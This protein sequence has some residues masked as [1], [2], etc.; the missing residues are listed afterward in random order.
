V[1]TLGPGVCVVVLLT[2]VPNV[3]E[4]SAAA[5]DGITLAT[6]QVIQ[7][8]VEAV[9]KHVPGTPDES[10]AAVSGLTYRNRVDMNA[11]MDLFL[12][13]LAGYK[14]NT[15]FNHS[16]DQ[17]ADIA[18]GAGMPDAEEFLKRA[19]VLHTDAA[20][21][22]D[23]FPQP[24]DTT[25]PPSRP[26]EAHATRRGSSL[27]RTPEPS[28]APLLT[29]A[30]F[31]RQKDGD[32]LGTTDANW[33]WPFARSLLA[34]LTRIQRGPDDQSLNAHDPFVGEWY[35]AVASFLFAQRLYGEA[36]DHFSHAAQ[37]LA[38]D[39]RLLFDR[40]CYAEILGLP[41]H[42]LFVSDSVAGAMRP[43]VPP[44][45]ETNGE[46]ERLFRRALEVD[47][48]FVE[49][50]VHLARLL[51][52]R[53]AD[54][55]A[56]SQLNTAADSNPQGVVGFYAHLFDARVSQRRGALDDA[57]AQ[58]REALA[59]YPHAQSALLGLSQVGLAGGDAQ[60]ALK[61]LERLGPESLK[62]DADPWWDYAL[63]SGRDVNELMQHVW[64]M[65]R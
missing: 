5:A 43:N 54:A 30:T 10:I 58:Y 57:A 13:A 49:A 1:R 62:G 15:N 56:A 36:T 24:V 61:A 63:A 41:V 31:V 65:G 32:V 18:H 64:T 40:G 19:T 22:V 4:R 26:S 39:P 46:A 14:Y 37:V 6:V 59:L 48:S 35:H 44:L 25:V 20:I 29:I 11:G 7:A 52:I 16:A 42:Q 33:N 17:V 45:A 21:F 23:K 3:D 60:A 9:H 8:W 34:F 53:G 50:R 28:V 12:H 2:L 51:D 38:D 27:I 47:P 55:E